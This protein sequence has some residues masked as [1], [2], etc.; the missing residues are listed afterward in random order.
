[1]VNSS[2]MP[3]PLIEQ[4]IATDAPIAVLLIEDN[5]GDAFLIQGM[6]GAVKA[7]DLNAFQLVH[8]ERLKDAIATLKRQPVN[9][10]LLDLSLPD[11]KGLQ[12]VETLEQQF[13]AIPVVILTGQNDE[14]FA[15]RA[16]HAGAQDYLIK[17]QVTQEVLTRSIR[18]AI[19]RQSAD[20]I[21]RQQTLQLEQ[22][23]QELNHQ[24]QQ[25]AAVNA[26]LEAFNYTIAHDL[27]HPLA[28]IKTACVLLSASVGDRDAKS[29]RYTHMIQDYSHQMAEVFEGLLQL[30]QLS[31]SPL[32]FQPVDLSATAQMIITQLKQ[33]NPQHQVQVEIAPHLL[34]K[35]DSRLLWILLDHL[36]G[37]AFKF[38]RNSSRPS[39][40]IELGTCR[41]SELTDHPPS[42]LDHR[43]YYVTDNGIGFDSAHR[44]Q[45]FAPFQTFAAE[46]AG[47]GIGL[48]MARCIVNRHQGQ[49]WY[50][51]APNQGA[52]FY[53]TLPEGQQDSN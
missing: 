53:W 32:Q 35:G 14:A 50:K 28:G 49:I 1:M 43:V 44:A 3:Q 5:P 22:A 23:N 33:Q 10:I 8:V 51:A 17:G 37:N 36:L 16:V 13:P 47:Q 46:S 31:Q 6:L 52:T 39:A 30:A 11:S 34:V 25:L 9:V 29:A 12:A 26:D 38:T 19:E 27:R 40:T 4:D 18:Y 48:T 42:T 2:V 41:L 7:S 21:L 24:A 15:T 45:V 20:E